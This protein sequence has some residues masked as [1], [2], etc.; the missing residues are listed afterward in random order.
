MEDRKIGL[1]RIDIVGL[2]HDDEVMKYIIGLVGKMVIWKDMI[3][4]MS[5]VAN[6]NSAS[7]RF[8]SGSILADTSSILVFVACRQGGKSQEKHLGVKLK[9][10]IILHMLD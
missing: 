6:N 7:V 2:E 3:G 10:S 5:D 4:W 9:H 1:A 8:E